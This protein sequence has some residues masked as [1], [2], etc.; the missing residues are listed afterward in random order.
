MHFPEPRANLFFSALGGMLILL[1]GCA[2]AWK[3][4]HR[5]LAAPRLFSSPETELPEFGYPLGLPETEEI[6]TPSVDLLRATDLL[7]ESVIAIESGGDPSLVGSRG[8]RGLMQVMPG[9][10]GD[11]TRRHFEEPVPFDRAFDPEW[12]RRVGRL[13]LGD[14]QERLYKRRS[15]W[16][17]DV[18]L[19]L[20]ASYNAGFDRV[21]RSG[22]D[23]QNLPASVQDYATRASALHDWHLAHDRVA[24]HELLE[25]SIPD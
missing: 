11:V 12:N 2:V 14:L 15:E 1:L 9:T 20:F 25:A 16:N 23:L 17:A 21:A 19:L 10:W 6:E 13:C 8:E 4:G 3:I 5:R 7:I 22:F 18:R 24:I